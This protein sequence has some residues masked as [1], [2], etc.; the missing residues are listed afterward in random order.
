MIQI[1]YTT[2]EK[3]NFM[4][5]SSLV[6]IR[7]SSKIFSLRLTFSN[8]TPFLVNFIKFDCFLIIMDLRSTTVKNPSWL[9]Y[10]TMELLFYLSTFLTSSE[11]EM[12]ERLVSV[13]KGV[14]GYWL[15]KNTSYSIFLVV[16]K[17]PG[18]YDFP[19]YSEN[20]PFVIQ[21]TTLSRRRR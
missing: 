17:L 11:M 10:T 18:Y 1:L 4:T 16:E 21:H 12:T 7:L 14:L 15:K 6:D 8:I 19:G 13:I 9:Q 2:M 5:S 20:H 3:T